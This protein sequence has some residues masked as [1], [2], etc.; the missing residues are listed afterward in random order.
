[1]EKKTLPDFDF[2]R[3]S[4]I[5]KSSALYSAPSL[6]VAVGKL[7]VDNFDS[8]EIPFAEM[9]LNEL[10][11]GRYDLSIYRS[12]YPVGIRNFSVK[13]DFSITTGLSN[14]LSLECVVSGGT[15]LDLCGNQFRASPIPRA[16]LSS[17]KNDGRQTRL[18]RH[19]DKVKGIGL[20]F[21]PELLIDGLGIT[22]DHFPKNL[23]ELL[24]LESENT[25]SFKLDASTCR[26][27]SD[28]L[29]SSFKGKLG[30][31]YRDA[32]ITELLCHLSK[33]L[34]DPFGSTALQKPLS[35]RKANALDCVIQILNNNLAQSYSLDS[36]ASQA[37]VSRTV[38]T[39]T[40]K[41]SIGMSIAQY[42]LKTRMEAA[43][44]LLEDGGL[45]IL[46]VS[47]AV[48]YEDQ[49][50]FGRAYKRFHGHPPREDKISA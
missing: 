14:I 29:G 17:Y 31:H 39:S 7:N 41:G 30:G 33:Y 28:L 4:H 38:L 23:K 36:L 43:K 44:D 21:S 35:R 16:Y 18:Y 25:I 24:L 37:G 10:I 27:I 40:F 48:G 19:K 20:W 1:L 34:Q 26:V 46:E 2:F 5:R 22:I 49:S 9:Y 12:H 3:N 45:T 13:R 50:S 6:A 32:K 11:E 47:L 42:L 8:S 15:D